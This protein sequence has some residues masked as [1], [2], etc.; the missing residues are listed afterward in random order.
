[1]RAATVLLLM[2]LLAGCDG[3]NSR[4]Y[5]LT[6]VVPAEWQTE[7]Y[8]AYLLDTKTG[9]VWRQVS[10]GTF[11]PQMIMMDSAILAPLATDGWNKENTRVDRLHYSYEPNKKKDF[12]SGL[13]K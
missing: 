13:F 5:E 3:F 9:R 1:M 12:F 4:R 6:I 11:R 8:G 7:R 10:D 2:V